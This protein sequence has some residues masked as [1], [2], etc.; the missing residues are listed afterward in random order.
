MTSST[1]LEA[2]VRR[3][4][5][6]TALVG[7][8]VVLPGLVASARADGRSVGRPEAVLSPV[9]LSLVSLGWFGAATLLWRP[10]PLRL[11]ARERLI[12]LLA[13][14]PLCLTG[15]ALAIGARLALGGSYRVASTFGLRLAPKHRLVTSGPYS[16][17]RHPMYVGLVMAAIGGLLLY[18]TWAT[19]LFVVQLPSLFARARLE[20]RALAAE[21]GPEW[22]AYRDRVPGWFPQVKL[23]LGSIAALESGPSSSSPLR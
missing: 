2:T 14:A 19:L 4:G 23:R 20:D 21:F 9:R 12:F 17:V 15:L 13:G 6:L 3:V 10:L 18:R 7:G 5:A 8:M 22:S 11:Q 1:T 16:I